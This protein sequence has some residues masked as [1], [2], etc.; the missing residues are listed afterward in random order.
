MGAQF[1]NHDARA[2]EAAAEPQ[3]IRIPNTL[4]DYPWPKALNPY[5]EE[6]AK[7]SHEWL[8]SFGILSEKQL[9]T[10]WKSRNAYLTSLAWPQ[11]PKHGCQIGCDLMNMFYIL[12]GTT[13][14][15]PTAE[16]AKVLVDCFMDALRHPNKPRPEEEWKGAKVAQSF[17][18]RMISYGT[19]TS[20]I[21]RF[22]Y[23]MQEFCDGVVEQA[24]DRSR[25]HIR[26]MEEYFEVRRGTIGAY[27]CFVVIQHEM[28]MPDDVYEHDILRKLEQ[29]A[30]DMIILD[31]DLLSYNV[32]QARGDEAHNLV[33]VVMNQFGLGVQESLHYVGSYH[34]KVMDEFLRV[35]KNIPAVFQGDKAI[36]RYAWGVA[37]WVRANWQW[38]WETKRYFPNIDGLQALEQNGG[39]IP[40][41]PKTAGVA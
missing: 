28:D 10:A 12:D 39:I 36:E 13:D 30:A 17:M 23:R 2:V 38:S 31:N 32:E 41:I 40:L 34:R 37:N 6:C 19:S 16:E 15:C 29:L 9:A 35:Y 33:K 27:P 21:R 4:A 8:A 20:C 3:F 14:R 18:Q 11:V 5:E 22:V 1:D 7:A 26:S 24:G 25:D